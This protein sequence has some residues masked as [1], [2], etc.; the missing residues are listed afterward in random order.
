MSTLNSRTDFFNSCIVAPTRR[1]ARRLAPVLATWNLRPAALFAAV[2]VAHWARLGTEIG[3]FDSVEAK[4]VIAENELSQFWFEL[5]D[6]GL[7]SAN[8][9]WS[10][11]FI[12]TGTKS[13]S[14]NEALFPT[15][16]QV[17]TILHNWFHD[18]FQSLLLLTSEHLLTPE[19]HY[20]LESIGWADDE[21]WEARMRGVPPHS[22]GVGALW[23]GLSNVLSFWEE[24]QSLLRLIHRMFNYP[25]QFF[26]GDWLSQERKRLVQNFLGETCTILSPRFNLERITVQ[27][28]YF[29]IAGEFVSLT[30]QHNAEWLD[31]RTQVFEDLILQMGFFNAATR[32]YRGRFW[33]VYSESTE[34]PLGR[35]SVH[36]SRTAESQSE[37]FPDA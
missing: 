27:E 32:D 14:L 9:A 33:Q 29:L 6:R 37:E 22:R 16:P 18:T 17:D 34:R 35:L 26:R 8:D 31:N 4:K 12:A 13:P 21:E 7:I 19:S 15:A 30:R 28:R 11:I 2:E 10:Q 25:K 1:V 5:Y 20:F 24:L 36:R 3:Y 23:T